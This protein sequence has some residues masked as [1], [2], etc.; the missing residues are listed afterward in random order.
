MAHKTRKP[1]AGYAG[2]RGFRHAATADDDLLTS[3]LLAVYDGQRCIG[4]IISRGKCG[5]EAFD[6]D[7]RSLGMFPD[8]AS[9]VAAINAGVGL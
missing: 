1:G 2:L 4:H 6:V 3:P 8:Q 5:H 9:A 7:D